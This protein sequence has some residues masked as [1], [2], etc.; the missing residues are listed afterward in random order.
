MLFCEICFC[1]KKMKRC[2]S[3]KDKAVSVFPL[4]KTIFIAKSMLVELE[5]CS[6]KESRFSVELASH[7]KAYNHSTSLTM[8]FWPYDDTS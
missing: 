3:C 8:L 5:N 4:S 6:V 7:L 2:S 1:A